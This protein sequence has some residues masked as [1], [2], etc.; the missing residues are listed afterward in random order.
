MISDLT[1]LRSAADTGDANAMA[2]YGKHLISES[3]SA[4]SGQKGQV[5]LQKAAQAGNGEAAEFIAIMLASGMAGQQDWNMALDYLGHAASMNWAPA[6]GQLKLLANPENPQAF[7]KS[8]WRELRDAIDIEKLLNIPE[9][10]NLCESPR[11]RQFDDFLPHSFCDWMIERARPRVSRARIYDSTDVKGK[12]TQDRTN[13]STNFS[14][15]ELDLVL[16]LIQSRVA[17]LAN[18]PIFA[19]EKSM[20]LHYEPGQEFKPHYDYLDPTKPAQIADMRQFGQRLATC[21]IYLNDD[22]EGAETAFPKLGQKFRCEKGGALVFANIDEQGQPDP[23]TL[24]AGLPP[25]RGE[26]WLFSQWIRSGPMPI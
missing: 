25:T 21:L 13:S 5:L 1:A 20:V 6:V 26:K 17:K 12:E 18:V 16:I 8:D 15:M 9:R 22:F 4:E 10:R 7:D 19:M 11:I 23:Q 3:K 24:H 14:L 2:K